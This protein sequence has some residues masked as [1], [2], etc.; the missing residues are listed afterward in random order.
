MS[1]F[2]ARMKLAA[3]SAPVQDE[4]IQAILG[5][6]QTHPSRA[7]LFSSSIAQG[8]FSLLFDPKVFPPTYLHPPT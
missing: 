2:G 8:F 6:T 3:I 1:S 4:A 7:F 5:W